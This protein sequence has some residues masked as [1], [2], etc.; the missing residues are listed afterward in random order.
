MQ[1][2]SKQNR[3]AAHK[4]RSLFDQTLG[5]HIER[6]LGTRYG[7]GALP[8]N[9]AT[10]SC[11]LLLAERE[12]EINSLPSNPS[13]RYTHET[14]LNELAEIGLD[15]DENLEMTFQDIIQ[16]GYIDVDD[17]GRYS[18]KKPTISM[19]QLLDKAF[20]KMPG[21]NLVA[22]FVQTLKEAQSGRKDLDSAISQFDQILQMQGVPLSEQRTQPKPEK[23]PSP[24]VTRETKP[25]KIAKPRI[26]RSEPKII[27]SDGSVGQFEIREAFVE[28]DDSPETYPEMD[29][30]TEAQEPEIPEEAKQEE[31]AVEEK[32][33][34]LIPHGG[35]E[36]SYAEPEISSEALKPGS[37]KQDLFEEAVPADTALEDVP[38]P[39][40]EPLKVS[41][42][43]EQE[44]AP[45]TDVE[46]QGAE[47]KS[48]Q[49]EATLQQAETK[50][51]E[52]IVSE[53]QASER[54]DEIIEK[55]IVSFEQDL[56]MQ[57]PI[58]RSAEVQTQETATGKTYYKCS[59]KSCNFISWGKPFHLVCP[60]CKNP[61]LV[62]TPDRDGKTI[63]KCP[64]A[65]CHYQQKLPWEITEGPPK[66]APSLPEESAKSTAIPQ[67]KRRRAVR[68]RVVRRKR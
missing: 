67:K 3:P 1:K 5:Q 57:C 29:E 52:E 42:P 25:K 47:T 51:E 16:K 21:M 11:L 26:S 19:A 55:R 18:A 59:N 2:D 38:S 40:E 34:E 32:P 46:I 37:D 23:A 9:L 64:R 33:V 50:Y 48:L 63:L 68:R 65:T 15:P 45:P 36:G 27:S 44:T 54:A 20:P 6:L 39:Q 10:I 13:E 7:I 49:A 35:T 43:I 62:E 24:P 41:E 60:Q 66:E 53:E 61:F 17:D 31:P 30:A 56:A 14:L 22:Y 58:C 28:Q 4:V 12:T 8:I